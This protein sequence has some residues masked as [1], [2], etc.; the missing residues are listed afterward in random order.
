MP[1]DAVNDKGLQWFKGT[2]DNYMEK[3]TVTGYWKYLLTISSSEV[4]EKKIE[5]IMRSLMRSLFSYFSLR[6]PL[7]TTAEYRPLVC[8]RLTIYTSGKMERGKRNS[9][10]CNTINSYD[11]NWQVVIWIRFLSIIFCQLLKRSPD[12]INYPLWEQWQK[13]QLR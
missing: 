6:H 2:L 12:L 9:A 5:L 1:T 3:K 11:L 10:S 4:P 8:S 13:F 7:K